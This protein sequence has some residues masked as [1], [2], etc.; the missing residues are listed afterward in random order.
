MGIALVVVQR[1]VKVDLIGGLALFGVVML[2]ISA[3]L[4]LAL[5]GRHGG[6]DAQH[7]LQRRS[8]RT[9]FLGDGPAGGNRLGK[10]LTRYLPYNDIDPAG[11]RSGW[12][13]SG[14]SWPR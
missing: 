13:F 10:A 11:W 3:G 9:L 7:D 5:P 12:A 6:Q 14:W 2:L 1:F 4:A 8:A